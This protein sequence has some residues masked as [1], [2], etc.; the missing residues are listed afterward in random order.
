MCRL[1]GAY[2]LFAL[3]ADVPVFKGN[4]S[5]QL[6]HLLTRPAHSIINQVWLV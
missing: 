2:G 1:L 4:D 5:I 6:S 3:G